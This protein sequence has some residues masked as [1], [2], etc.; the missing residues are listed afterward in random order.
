MKLED[1]RNF[2]IEHADEKKALF[3][4]KIIQ[5][6]KKMYGVKTS[7]LKKIAKLAAKEEISF[8]RHESYEMDVIRGLSYF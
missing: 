7:D 2:I 5:S 3:D 1:I 8:P 4:R 6:K